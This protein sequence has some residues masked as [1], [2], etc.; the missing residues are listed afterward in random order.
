MISIFLWLFGFW[1][2][3]WL[4]CHFIYLY[5][6]VT[7]MNLL[8]ESNKMT[9][10]K[11]RDRIKPKTKT[12]FRC[13]RSKWLMLWYIQLSTTVFSFDV[14]TTNLFQWIAK[15]SFAFDLSL[16]LEEFIERTQKKNWN[17]AKVWIDYFFLY[18][19]LKEFL[20]LLSNIYSVL[21]VLVYCFSL[22]DKGKKRKKATI[23]GYLQKDLTFK[24]VRCAYYGQLL[25][26]L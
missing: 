6:M 13:W 1:V 23:A 8:A 19:P 21:S 10:N 26:N 15:S 12:Y 20:W 5:H 7:L 16:S 24:H 2:G 17:R 18:L 22:N 25:L 9:R 11:N 3:K 14:Q 4:I